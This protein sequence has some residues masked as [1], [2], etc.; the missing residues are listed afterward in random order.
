MTLP[1]APSQ[2]VDGLARRLPGEVRELAN[3]LGNR[4]VVVAL[5]RE[6]A[7]SAKAGSSARGDGPSVPRIVGA[8]SR[9]TRD[10]RPPRLVVSTVARRGP[11]VRFLSQ[12]CGGRPC[13][14]Q[15]PVVEARRRLDERQ[16]ARS[17]P[18]LADVARH[19]GQSKSRRP[20]HRIDAIAV[21]ACVV[22]PLQHEADG[23]VGRGTRLAPEL[24]PREG[25]PV[26]AGEVDRADD[27]R[28]ELAAPEPVARRWPRLYPRGLVAGDREARAADAEHPARSGWPPRRP[29]SPSSGSPRAPARRPVAAHRSSRRAR[30]R[31]APVRVRSHSR[32]LGGQ[33]P[34]QVE[35]GRVQ[36]EPDP[37]QDTRPRAASRGVPGGIAR[38][39]R[40]RPGA[41]AI[42]AGSISPSSLGGMRNRPTGQL[43]RADA[44]IRADARLARGRA[45]GTRPARRTSRPGRPCRR[46]RSECGLRRCGCFGRR[47]P[48]ADDAVAG[49]HSSIRT[50]ALMPPKP[51]PL[52]AARRGRPGPGPARARRG[53]GR[54][55]GWR[56]ARAAGSDARSSRS[57]GGCDAPGPAGP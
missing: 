10:V 41:S 52:M 7:G 17:R 43:E 30:P 46:W 44:T 26:V 5:E 38:S 47:T 9:T 54:G 45:P 50:W 35:V 14:R 49:I 16:Q 51:N 48:P 28:V 34:A 57:A 2:R 18:G 53:S 15:D 55:T 20:D 40:P 21:A 8:S 37:D 27:R 25:R 42:A 1:P 23:R 24:P 13:R 19:A 3:P 31:K 22:E 39:P 29:A 11:S 32:G 36:V 4:R 6:Q 56:R 12:S 33:R